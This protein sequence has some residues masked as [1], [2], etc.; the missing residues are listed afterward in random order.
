M[1]KIIT[2]NCLVSMLLSLGRE[3]RKIKT[4][5]SFTH[6]HSVYKSCWFRRKR[7][8]AAFTV[9]VKRTTH[10]KNWYILIFPVSY[11]KLTLCNKRR[12]NGTKFFREIEDCGNFFFCRV[13]DDFFYPILRRQ[14][15]LHSLTHNASISSAH[16][17]Y[18]Y[19]PTFCHNFSICAIIFFMS[20]F[21]AIY[22]MFIDLYSMEH[23]SVPFYDQ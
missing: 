13:A 17:K 3:R 7:H 4:R 11:L 14:K 1:W 8:A 12:N 16:K 22:L 2:I 5:L 21:Y 9:Y 10:Y 18:C 15:S 6:F 19:V 20:R 23:I